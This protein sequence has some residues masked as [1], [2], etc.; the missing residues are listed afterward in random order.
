MA[1]HEEDHAGDD[2]EEVAPSIDVHFEPIVQLEKVVVQTLEENEEELFVMRAKL[3]R[4]DKPKKEWKERGTGDV[5]LLKNKETGKV[6]LLMRRERILKICAN[7]IVST[8][9]K[10]EEMNERSWVWTVGADFSENEPRPE[11]FAI[12]FANSENA[13]KFKEAFENAGK[14]NSGAK[15]E[16]KEEKEEKKEE[17]KEEEKEEKKEE[18]K[19]ADK[20]TEA[21]DKLKVADA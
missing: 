19:E 9:M 7:H 21:L 2:N 17:K 11:V 13:Q 4:F 18:S 12:R 6:R 10:L 5:K 3:F 1:S 20:V 14:I 16:Q 15:V 8:E